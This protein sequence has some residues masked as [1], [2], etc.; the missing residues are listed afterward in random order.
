MNDKLILKCKNGIKEFSSRLLIGT[1]KYESFEQNRNALIASGAEIITVAV[2]RVNIEQ[3]K[4]T[5]F[6]RLH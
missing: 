6:T 4:S 2:R 3:K 1:G 5:T